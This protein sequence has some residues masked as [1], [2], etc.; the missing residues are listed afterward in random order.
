MQIAICDDD[1]SIIERVNELLNEY[2]ESHG[3]E[4]TVSRFSDGEALIKS[5]IRFDMAFIDVEMPRVN[6]LEAAA[7]VRKN[8]RNAVIIIVS[9]YPD[10][11]DDAMELNVYRFLSK[12]IDKTRFMNSISAALK[13]YFAITEP[14]LLQLSDETVKISTADIIYLSID[15]R[16]I[17]VHTLERDY[18]S[19]KNMEW[20]K[21]QL[22]PDLFAQSHKSYLVNLR[23]VTNFD[24]TTVTLKCGGK[25][26][27]LYV[28]Q[29]KYV[30]FKNAFYAYLKHI[31][32]HGGG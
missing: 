8:N 4:L 14:V 9:S 21:K 19:S 25:I 6:G 13:R 5:G 18:E 22:N 26:Y 16:K 24:K 17:I 32:A 3:L 30:K 15:D 1:K 31:N 27:K 7:Y 2:F 10:Y 11:L 12:P 23:Y 29:R 20:W 28:S